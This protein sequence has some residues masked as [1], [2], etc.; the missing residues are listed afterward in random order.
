MILEKVKFDHMV[1][2]DDCHERWMISMIDGND[3]ILRRSLM[4]LWDNWMDILLII[5]V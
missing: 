4:V 1:S 3:N 5:I 2:L